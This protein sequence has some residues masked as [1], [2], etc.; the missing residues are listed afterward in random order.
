[1]VY[2]RTFYLALFICLSIATTATA[3]P[4]TGGLY[5]VDGDSR[6]LPVRLYGR[7]DSPSVTALLEILDVNGVIQGL[8]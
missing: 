8:L 3:V 7:Y 2:W 6:S 1:M 4:V 5:I